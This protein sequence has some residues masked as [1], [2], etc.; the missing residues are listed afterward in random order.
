MHVPTAL[1]RAMSLTAVV[2]ALATGANAASSFRID[3]LFLSLDGS[4]QYIVLR[5]SAGLDGEHE[6]GGTTLRSTVAG[7]TRVYTI[8]RVCTT[9]RRQARRSSSGRRASLPVCCVQEPVYVV[10]SGTLRDAV[11]RGGNGAGLL[12]VAGAIPVGR[13]RHRRGGRRRRR[14]LRSVAHVR[15][16]RARSRRQGRRRR[17]PAV[18]GRVVSVPGFDRVRAGIRRLGPRPRV[19]PRGPGPLPA[20]EPT[21]RT[22]RRSSEVSPRGGRSSGIRSTSSPRRGRPSEGQPGPTRTST[23]FQCAATTFRPRSTRISCRHPPPSARRSA[24]CRARYSKATRRS[25][26]TAPTPCQAPAETAPR[27]TGSGTAAPTRTTAGRRT[28]TPGPRCWRWAGCP[29]APARSASRSAASSTT[30]SGDAPA[31]RRRRGRGYHHGR[32]RHARARSRPAMAASFHGV[33]PILYAFFDADGKP[34]RDGI[35]AQVEAAVRHGA[36]GVAVLGIATETNKLDTPSGARSS[37]GPRRRC[38][39]ACRSRSPSPSP[40]CTARSRSRARRRRRA[41]TG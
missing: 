7:V 36:H 2:A 22:S 14:H 37:S 1:L 38:A 35:V 18:L 10:E 24:R 28:P 31:S 13:G 23:P 40:R 6:L 5:E 11:V 39:G 32:G 19:L 16:S 3:Q 30:I 41:P 17:H 21:R 29:K 9:R 25:M 4:T 8:P 27:C 34:L 20:D 12:R 15:P 33:Y 26:P